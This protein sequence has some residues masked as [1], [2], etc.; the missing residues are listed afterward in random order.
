MAENVVTV[1]KPAEVAGG[2]TY[3][4]EGSTLPEDA[5]SKLPDGYKKLGLVSVDGI[6]LT[7]DASD[8]D[9]YVWGGVKY[10]KVRSEFSES[11]GAVLYSTTN[12]DTL[13][14]VFGD[15]NVEVNGDKIVIKH[16]ADIP[17]IKVF[18]VE[19]FDEG[20][21]R[22]FLIPRGQLTVSG[23]RT[24]AHA[25]ADQF[26]IAIEALADEN[27]VTMLECLDK[28]DGTSFEDDEA[29]SGE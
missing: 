4:P 12:P 14:A 17:P 26:E 19:T 18:T 23:D 28:T 1:G 25:S 24:L 5:S 3:A 10:R 2:F 7:S 22:R 9:I 13:R 21:K 15:K 6:T 20:I 16:T 8:E 29:D 27:G 11:L